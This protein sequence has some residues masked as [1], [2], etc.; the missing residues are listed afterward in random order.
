LTLGVTVGRDAEVPGMPVHDWTRI[1]AGTFH[2]FHTAW[3][4]HLS[5][6]LNGGLL[7][8]GYYALPEQP[9]GRPIADVLTLHAGPPPTAATKAG[10][11]G[12]LAV[13]EAPPRVSRRLTAAPTAAARRRT[14]AVRHVSGHRIA[15]LLE[16]VSPANKDRP[17]HVDDLAGMIA[18][19]LGVGVNAVLADLFPPGPHDPGGLHGAVWR[20][21]DA[22]ADGPDPRDPP[23][24]DRPVDDKPLALAA[25]A[26]GPEVEAYL[27]PLA[28]GDPVPDMPLFLG[29]G[30]YVNAPL[31]RTYDAAFRGLPAIWRQVLERP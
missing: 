4:T 24:G 3:V 19:A 28:A 15:A 1:D 25:Y 5:E 12:G 27:E 7:P 22:D 26:A 17:K 29:P 23:P 14:L 20:L 2:V 9:A 18:A 11:D 16:I 21:V 8:A 31:G 30:R 6:A 13:A 10:G